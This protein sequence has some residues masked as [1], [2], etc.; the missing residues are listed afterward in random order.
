MFWPNLIILILTILRNV[1]I[2]P[3]VIHNPTLILSPHVF[4]L[5][6][7]FHM[8]AFANISSPEQLYR[9][10]VPSACNELLIPLRTELDEDFLFCDVKPTNDG[11]KLTPGVKFSSSRI[12]YYMKQGGEE[13]GFGQVTKPYCLRDG[14]AQTFNQSGMFSRPLRFYQVANKDK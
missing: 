14:A 8:R 3:E 7:L 11:Y 12:R 1:F 10:R 6:L 4:L 9:L 5:S 2:L 13:T